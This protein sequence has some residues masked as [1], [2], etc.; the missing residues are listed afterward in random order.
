M[1]HS[2]GITNCTVTG[3]TR[4]DRVVE[5][6]AV[7]K[8]IPLIEKFKAG[9][10]VLIAGSTWKEDEQLI[11]SACKNFSLHPSP[12]KL[13]IAPHEINAIK[14]KELERLF[15]GMNTARFS[16][17]NEK[18]IAGSQVLIIDNIG[19]LSAIY[20]YGTGAFIG[21]GFRKPGCIHAGK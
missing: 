12:F 4:F 18:I 15:S 16:E 7:V 21:G 11:L 5:S 9:N 3:D 2:I 14:I 6:A 19:M 20:Q 17:A 10:K 8:P 1:L 13:I